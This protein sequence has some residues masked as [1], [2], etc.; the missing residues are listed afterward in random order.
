MDLRLWLRHETRPTERRAPIV[1]ADAARLVRAG[2]S[3]TVEDSPQRVFDVAEYAAAGC[4]VAAP[5]SWVDAPAGTYVVGLKEL[6]P[7]PPALRHRH[8]FFTHAYKGQPGSG[9][10]LAR[11]AAGGGAIL[12]LEYLTDPAGR[13]LVA[14]G[15][16]AGYLGAALAVL[17]RHG[18]LETPLRPWSK[19]DLDRALAG[20]RDLATTALVIGALGRCGSGACAALVE[21][22]IEPTRWD[23]AETRELDRPALLDHDLL[24]NAVLTERP[25]PPFLT[26]DDLVRPRRLAVV[27]DVTCDVGSPYHLLPIYRQTTTWDTP[28]RALPDADPPL[29]VISLDNLPSL[30]PLEASVAFSADLLPHL[31]SLPDEDS[32]W[33]HC[34][35]RFR[36]ARDH[37]EPETEPR[38]A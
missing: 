11:F 6:P 1:P 26:T 28:A 27:A 8:V 34:L 37:L 24:I 9:E 17:H 29:A 3:V 7:D 22:G 36:Q 32:P 19:G 23:L 4:A 13:R 15:Y 5:D 33:R 18:S 14:F 10:L 31:L 25:A 30:L 12:D 16:W 21:A 20:T 35:E 2:A 38:H